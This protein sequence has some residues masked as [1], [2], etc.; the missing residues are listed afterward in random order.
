[1]H[2]LA[3][4]HEFLP[5]LSC[6]KLPFSCSMCAV[7][8]VEFVQTDYAVS[9]G[10]GEV[11]VCLMIDKQATYSIVARLFVASGTAKGL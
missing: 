1:M 6:Q 4:A 11:E 7:P 8:L 3:W 2:A 9:E 10:D 5:Y